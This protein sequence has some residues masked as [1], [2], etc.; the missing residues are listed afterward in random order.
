M[1]GVETLHLSQREPVGELQLLEREQ[2]F[3]STNGRGP[4][5][6]LHAPSKM[7][8]GGVLTYYEDLE[9]GTMHVMIYKNP[10]SFYTDEG[11]PKVSDEEF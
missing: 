11:V 3:F 4:L 6:V 7:R 5:H 8:C 9:L 1:S 10:L 2:R